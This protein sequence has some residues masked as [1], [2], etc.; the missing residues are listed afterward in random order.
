MVKRRQRSARIRR[1]KQKKG[2]YMPVSGK[3]RTDYHGVR[4]SYGMTRGRGRAGLIQNMLKTR[5]M[6]DD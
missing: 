6:T 4:N 3:R 2:L 5:L 1:R